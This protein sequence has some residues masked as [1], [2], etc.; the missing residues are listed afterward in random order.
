M[1][2]LK[3]LLLPPGLVRLIAIGIWPST[4][5]PA[6]TV[7]QFNPLV[8]PER[9]QLFA[10]D[11]SLICFQLPPFHTIADEVSGGGAGDF[12][13]RFGALNQIVPEQALV[14]GDFGM[15]SDSPIVLD[16]A[17]NQSNP[18]VLRLRWHSECQYTEWVQGAK[19]FDD[20]A[21]ML[22]L[23]DGVA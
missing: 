15:G 10:A 1:A 11:E 8:P 21:N 18:P 19:D 23:T 5:G 20:F 4:N 17:A 22:G 13:Q 6:M 7:L 14:I 12:W 16:F 2:S 3:N 9:V